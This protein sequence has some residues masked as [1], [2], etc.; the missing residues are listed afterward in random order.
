MRLLMKT[1]AF[2]RANAPVALQYKPH[3]EKE[4]S[5]PEFSKFLYFLFAPTLIYQN[6]YPRTQS[7]RWGY[8]CKCFIEVLAC[9]VYMSFITERF[10]IR[11]FNQFGVKSFGW[12][13]ITLIVLGNGLAGI[14]VLLNTFY[15]VLHCWMNGFAEMLRFGD[16]LFYEDW[17]T[18]TTYSR[19]YR[20]W[21]VV[22]HDWLYAYIYKDMYEHVVPGNILLAKLT[23]FFVSAMVHE[24][25]LGFAFRFCMPI[26]FIEFFGLGVI[27]S[28][29]KSNNKAI[30]NAAVWYGLGC[31]MGIG[32][33]AYALEFYAR[34]NCPAQSGGIASYFIPRSIFC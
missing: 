21:N 26:L 33:S 1:H 20:T 3:T 27:F 22:V 8:V 9:M 5:I 7:I 14:L 32:V 12:K 10:L 31:G 4:V 18:S 28:F 2:I 19:Y 16:R 25:I 17:W 15:A 30:G 34:L 29:L 6:S 11:E 24:Y 23:V 13:E